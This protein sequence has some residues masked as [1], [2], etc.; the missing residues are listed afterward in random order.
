MVSQLPL[1]PHDCPRGPHGLANR[2]A[3][4]QATARPLPGRRQGGRGDRSRGERVVGPRGPRGQGRPDTPH[5][6]TD[7]GDAPPGVRQAYDGR[8]LAGAARATPRAGRATPGRGSLPVFSHI[9]TVAPRVLFVRRHEARERRDV[10]RAQ[11]PAPRHRARSLFGPRR[12]GHSLHA[13]PGH[14]TTRAAAAGPRQPIGGAAALPRS[15]VP[16]AL[17]RR[18]GG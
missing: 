3:G 11:P 4:G 1:R 5:E 17:S 9:A 14:P 18:R 15:V 12:R 10:G 13:L 2:G 7:E 8:P 6:M 16:R